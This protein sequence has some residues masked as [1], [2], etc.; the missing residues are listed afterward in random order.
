MY[1]FSARLSANRIGSCDLKTNVVQSLLRSLAGNLHQK[2]WLGV[3]D[4]RL[5]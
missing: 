4:L 3:P 1:A 5:S 2:P